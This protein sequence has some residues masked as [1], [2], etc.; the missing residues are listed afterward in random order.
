MK[1]FLFTLC[2]AL[3]AFSS[4]YA[5]TD[6]RQW[7]TH[8]FKVKIGQGDMFEKALAAHHKKYHTADPYKTGVFVIHTGP[9]SGEYELAIGPM[10]F[11]Q[12]AGRP[13][14][15]EHDADWQKVMSYVE[16]S[17]QTEYWRLDKDIVY[18]PEGA[19]A[20]RFNRWRNY[21]ILPGETDR[22]EE[23][24]NKVLAVYKAKNYKAAFSVYWKYGASQGPH[25]STE[26]S[27]DSWA[28][29]DTPIKFQE[30]FESV[31]GPDSWDR[32]M[33][34][35]DLCIERSKTYDEL[36]EFMPALSSD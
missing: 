14:G 9:S 36:V 22:F 16:A 26:M 11:S 2:L 32:F 31:H 13:A 20:Y 8:R 18:R 7:E 28:Y 23:Q 29:L 10:T 25:C 30:D 24:L 17:G 27:F 3:W 19:D 6:Y 15:T 33:E 1:N 4:G 21:T 5:Q 12:M 35:W 34:D